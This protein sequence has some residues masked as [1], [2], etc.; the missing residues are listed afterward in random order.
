MATTMTIN[1]DGRYIAFTIPQQQP[2]VFQPKNLKFRIK[3]N[4][5]LDIKS[6]NNQGYIPYPT[7]FQMLLV[8][9]E[10]PKPLYSL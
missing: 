10:V 3:Q 6:P 5:T 2:N 7:D 1:N 9:P 4:M 8:E